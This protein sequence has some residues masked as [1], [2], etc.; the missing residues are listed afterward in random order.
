MSQ[1]TNLNKNPYYDDFDA[2]SNY[3]KVL[4]KPGISVQTRELNNL[5]SI[6]QDQIDKFGNKF[7]SN[8]GMVVPGGFAYDNLV[9]AVEVESLFNGID[10]ETYYENF[11]G[12]TITGKESNISAIVE[13]VI[14]KTESERGSTTLYLK[15][16][17]SSISDFIGE[18]F[19]NA[20]ELIIN[21]DIEVGTSFIF[22]GESVCKVSS[23]IDRS[24]C[25][26]SSSVKIEEG[27]Y[28]IRG[29]FVNISEDIII[30]DQYSNSP[31]YRVG[32]QIL[33]ELVDSNDDLSLNDNA[34]GFSNYAA[35][36]ADRL[37][38]ST[39][40]IK[41]SLTDFND[42]DFI[43]LIRLENGIVRKIKSNDESSFISDILARRTFDESGNYS[44]SPFKVECLESLNNNLGNF[45]IYGDGDLTYEGS[46]PSID[47][48]LL[49]I[50]PGKAYV[51]GY[52]V[53]TSSNL[54]DFPKPRTT[55]K[56]E[57]SSSNFYAGNILRVNNVSGV[58]KIGLSTDV[59]ISLYSTRLSNGVALGTTIGVARVYDFEHHNTS[60]E[61]PESQFNLNLFDIQTYTNIVST[62]TTAAVTVGSFI[63]GNDSGASG[64]VNSVSGAN[65]SLLQVSG[66]FSVG[67]GFTSNGIG[68]TVSIGTVTDYSVGDIRSIGINGVS[69]YADSLLSKQTVIPGP[70]NINASSG[71]ATITVNN[72]SSF[73][74]NLKVNDIIKYSRSGISSDIYVGI[75]SI[76]STKNKIVVQELST[77]SNVC[78]GD[79]GTTSYDVQNISLI[80]PEIL[81]LDDSSLYSKLNHEN[82]SNVEFLNSSIYTKKYNQGVSKS[83]T[84]LTLPS[85]VG[86]DYVYASFDEE[87][88]VVV[89][90]NGSIE[91]LSSATFTISNG[92]KNAEFTNL[93]A[94]SGPCKVISTQIKSNVSSKL[95]QL[96]KCQK[97]DIEKTKYSVPKNAGLAYTTTYGTR[98]EDQEISLNVADIVQVHAVLESSTIV[99]PVIPA[100]TFSGLTS[101]N[102]S[103]DDL[104]VGELV[105]GS[106]SGAVAIYVSKVNSTK[107]SIIYKND[108]KFYVDEIIKFK[109][110]GYEAEVSSVDEGD[111]NI[112]NEFVLDNGQRKHYYDFGR[113]KRINESKEPSSRLTIIFDYFQFNST[114]S[115]DVITSNSYPTQLYQDH[116]PS[117]GNIRNTDVIDIRPRVSNYAG[118][119][120]SPFDYNS[121]KFNVTSNNSE[122]ILASNEDFVFD[123]E[124]YLPR[125]DKLTLSKTGDFEIVFGQPSEF[126]IEP[127]VSSEVLEIATIKNN[128]YVYD[129]TK[130]V[131]ISIT[132]NRRYTMSDLRNIETRVENLEYY[133]SLNLL[134]LSTRDLLIEDDNGLNRFKSG[135][136]V[137]NFNDYLTSDIDNPSY[138]AE[139]SNNILSPIV[140]KNY[141]PLNL[142]S[143][144]N[145]NSIS[146]VNLSATD[147]NNLR[148][149]GSSLTLNY[150]ET[151]YIFQNFASRTVKVNPYNIISWNGNLNISP[152]C[153]ELNIPIKN[154]NYFRSRNI[155]FNATGLKPNTKHSLIVDSRNLSNN[156]NGK[157]Y[158]FPKLIQIE[159]VIGN[160]AV[161][162]TVVG[163][164]QGAYIKFRICTPNHKFGAHDNPT[165]TYNLNP[166]DGVSGLSTSYGA[167]STILN[168]DTSS[169]QLDSIPEFFGNIL[170]GME[171][172]GLESKTVAKVSSVDLV[173]D[174]FGYVSGCIFIP[175][176]TKENIKFNHNNILIKLISD[177][178]ESFAEYVFSPLKDNFKLSSLDRY[179]PLSQSF[180][181][182]PE[183]GIIL[184]SVD[185][186]FN[187]KD[188][189]SPIS[190]EI[191]EVVNGLPGDKSKL[192]GNLKKI[193]L[194][195]EVSISSDASISTTFKFDTLTKLEGGREY[196]IIL[197]TN[198][199]NYE[200]WSGSVGS[201]DI[202]TSTLPEVNKVIISKQ[203]LI[204]NLFTAQNGY[205]WIANS[206]ASLKFKLNK[207]S[208]NSSG[209]ARLYNSSLESESIE[210]LLPINP[211]YTIADDG[212]NTAPYDGSHIKVFHPN[213]GMYG[214]SNKVKISGVESDVLPVKLTVS[215]NI[216]STG[217]ISV[218][219]T[220]IFANFEGS[221]VDSLNPG[222]I[223]IGEEIIKYEGISGNQLTGITRGFSNT[224]VFTHQP[225]SLVYKYEFNGVSLSKINITHTVSSS[226]EKGMD[227]YYI[228]VSI[229]EFNETKFG[230]G[231]NVYA[232]ENKNFGA[233]K[234]NS[235]FITNYNKTSVNANIRSITATSAD[236]SEISFVDNGFEPFDVYNNNNFK[237]LRMVASRVNENEYLN[238]T[239]FKSKKSLL[240]D[241]NLLTSD[242]NVSPILNLNQS[243]LISE[244]YRINRPIL[245][246]SYPTDNTVNSN[247]NDEHAFIHLSKKIELQETA[248]SLKVLLSSYRHYSSDIRVLY[249]IYKNDVP[250]EEQIWELF[251]GYDNLDVNNQIIN[252]ANNDGKSD[253]FV[254]NSSINEYRDYEFTIDSLPEFTAFAIKVVGSSDNQSYAPLIKDLRCIALK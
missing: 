40:L 19:L 192:V 66:T 41:K 108:L 154:K 180:T 222:Y 147:S 96:V 151:N 221:A 90:N 144:D 123:Y 105:V 193:L 233:L 249:K 11:V 211:L 109:E 95:K 110:S 156:I 129:V 92:G 89:N 73:A 254:P 118:G 232:S 212:S 185:I 122:Q 153:D 131:N 100:I 164:T 72:G 168:I 7:F 229:S 227:Y 28:F 206:E 33:E 38:I 236:G 62:A 166:Y 117:Y 88:Y 32:L 217:P 183:N 54:L 29:Y 21:S 111:K 55:Q 245:L 30:L 218:E 224:P 140:H 160:F 215:Y 195:S 250:D 63:K 85:L 74:R 167:Q 165:E 34:R 70:F 191:R 194:P 252:S 235:N 18:T 81:R 65:I 71:I 6:L 97:L 207:A 126:P 239:Q 23:P 27:I 143:D 243:G 231:S 8:G 172:H 220:A 112:L 58:P 161:G 219:S 136:F 138:K 3:Y 69:F 248:T 101:L 201:V 225:N 94:T 188:S 174:N 197:I 173:T 91:D 10:I 189:L 214:N 61:G 17:N 16:L 98:V 1:L 102:S 139:I 5:Q 77:V 184:T 237:T 132:D 170:V 116:I 56:I 130:D 124:F 177:N 39:N 93:S 43:E 86:T 178:T 241:L 134:E 210:T 240:L 150:T 59:N 84:T 199:N 247:L 52:E 187:K 162:E 57:S 137:D 64:F 230:G 107:I 20:E 13:Y 127:L 251:P 48:S 135:F 242:S 12:K 80:R 67:E 226:V 253:L 176:P 202:S 14:S 223:K 200:I 190:L 53:S 182:L 133:T 75:T 145:Q 216:T 198:S 169:L 155:E 50:S 205:N 9:G 163:K 78:S 119:I 196:A 125:T 115:G 171:L 141:I 179:N 79:V 238:A 146:E 26:I 149:T 203:P 76:F 37:K 175:D 44:V 246:D 42:T 4:F 128:A 106:Q 120:L 51:K 45:G 159:N 208:F 228:S 148:L 113:L 99:D 35:P 114:D 87:R 104:V 36:G 121:R 25:S 158:A 244:I 82:I 47:L 31:S 46:T 83:S 103:S 152:E 22:S 157:T 142:Y 2:E 60:Y 209:T 49:N 68:V 204:G 24:P 15:Y 181:V 213:H 186:F 234:L